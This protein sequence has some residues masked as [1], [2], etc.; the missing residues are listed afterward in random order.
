MRA[1]K[2]IFLVGLVLLLVGVSVALIPLS[3]ET[4]LQKEQPYIDQVLTVT[5]G[6]YSFP[7][8]QVYYLPEGSKEIAVS[9]TVRELR[10]QKFD[11][12]IFNKRNYELW[13]AN[14]STQAYAEA[15]DVS[16]YFLAFSPTRDDVSNGLYFVV[17][18]RN[19]ILGPDVSVE[20]SV[21]IS[22]TERSYA[23]IFGGFVLGI[24]LGGIGFLLIIA[25]AVM[26]FV[27]GRDREKAA[28]SFAGGLVQATKFCANCG[29]RVPA[30]TKFCSVCGSPRS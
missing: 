12:H 23:A 7:A 20:F 10:G 21:K 22:W 19:P 3:T 1:S 28:A 27:F 26:R 25:S 2:A 13:V 15:K 6:S 11:L 5:A 9:G 16:S 14:A 30:D 24:F 8:P 4:W 17:V 29:A 18:N